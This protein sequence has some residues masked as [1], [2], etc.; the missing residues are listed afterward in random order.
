MQEASNSL[1]SDPFAVE[2]PPA[3][4]PGLRSF[5]KREWPVF[6]GRELMT[7]EVIDRL[8]ARRFVVVHGDSGCGKSSLIR[9]GVQA[10]LEQ[11]QARS[12]RQWVTTDMRPGESPLWA[13][14][15]ALADDRPETSVRL[16]RRLLNRGTDAAPVLGEALGLTER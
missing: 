13:L 10:Q 6:F 7:T 12:G 9:A 5:E 8:M 1:P 11:E 2:L 4:Y 15:S 16:I 3:P 14:A